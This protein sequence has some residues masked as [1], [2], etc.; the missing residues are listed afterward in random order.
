MMM[1][2]TENAAPSKTSSFIPPI[3]VFPAGTP[4]DLSD[5]IPNFSTINNKLF[6]PQQV[7]CHKEQPKYEI[8][9]IFNL[10][11]EEYRKNHKLTTDQLNV[12]YAIEHCRTEEYGFHADVCDNC[13]H[14]EKAYNSCRNRHCPKCQGIA[15]RKWVKARIDELLPVSYHHATFTLPNQ[16]SVLSLH[17]Q[18]LIY[19]LLFDAASQTLLV[20]GDDP[21]WLGAKIG[22]YG[23]LHTWSQTLWPHVHLHFIVTAGGLSEDGKWIEPKYKGRFLFPVKALSKV[24]RGKFIEGL[25]KA[26]YAGELV[27]PDNL[28]IKDDDEF[29]QW[30]DLLVS[31]NWVVNS[32]PPF[33]GPEEVV[34]YIGRYTHRIAISN[35]RIIS[36]ADGQI[37]FSY[38]DNKEKDKSKVWKEMTLPADQFIK[39]FLWH[40]LPKRYHR[41]RHYGF[42]TNGKKKANLE[43]IREFFE[44]QEEVEEFAKVITAD[45]A[46]GITCPKCKK[47]KL[48]PFL[49]TSRYN[50][51]L[52]FDM[53]VF[54]KKEA[55][56][57]S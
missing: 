33:S 56:D 27:L 53:S 17:N 11:G 55:R 37:S 50:Q 9:D 41:I 52:K 49:V 14:I 20:F 26:Y 39:R 46:D 43:T 22:F 30:I 21:K 7:S 5:I 40:V 6:P 32:K 16:I 48:R 3:P 18:K 51:I 44:S 42:L 47:G 15:K 57:T 23:I 8:A 36:I 2:V 13:G 29:E 35:H 25:K 19:D 28:K 45:D 34:R 38:K 31:R 24:F 54:L 10:Y 4:I 12:M 1:P